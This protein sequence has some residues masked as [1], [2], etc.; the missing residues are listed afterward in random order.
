MR[1]RRRPLRPQLRWVLCYP[2]A[3]HLG[4]IGGH[5]LVVCGLVRALL[6]SDSWVRRR[7]PWAGMNGGTGGARPSDTLG[8]TLALSQTLIVP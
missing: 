8:H 4:L 5:C 3:L 2:D 1:A 6:L 7:E